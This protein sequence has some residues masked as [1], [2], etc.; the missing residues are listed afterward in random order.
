MQIRK[1]FTELW[2]FE[3]QVCA[4]AVAKGFSIAFI[5]KVVW[6]NYLLRF[7]FISAQTKWDLERILDSV[8]FS[9][10]N[11]LRNSVEQ[12]LKMTVSRQL[13][14][15]RCFWILAFISEFWQLFQQ[16]VRHWI[17]FFYLHFEASCISSHL[18]VSGF[19]CRTNMIFKSS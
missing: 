13:S 19:S 7:W 18:G 12:S 9:K 17:N 16:E 4:K 1:I 14:L 6:G 3:V 15:I 8:T 11:A 10:I 5:M 2:L